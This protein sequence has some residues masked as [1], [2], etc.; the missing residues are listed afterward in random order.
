MK[1]M[2]KL[3]SILLALTLLFALAACN[4][5]GENTEG[6]EGTENNENVENNG[7]TST[8]EFSIGVIQ[9]ASH[10]ALD[11]AREG[12]VAGLD[13][14]GLSYEI[15]VLNA[16]GEQANCPT[17]ATKLVND[18]VDLILAIATPAAQAAAQATDTIPILVTA[19]TDPAYAGLVESNDAPGGNVS[20]TSDM[21]P[22]EDQIEL[23][24]TL[25][26]ET[27]TVGLLYSNSEANSTTPIAEAK[28]Y[29]AG[30][31]NSI[32]QA[33]L[34]EEILTA[35]NIAV[36]HFTAS[37]SSQVQSV[38]QSMVGKVDAVYIPTDNL[39]AD[40][41]A[42]ISMVLTPEGIPTICGEGNMVNNGCLATYGFSYE[43]LGRQTAAQA[44]SILKDGADIST[45]PIGFY[46]GELELIVNDEVAAEL[47]IEIPA[48][49]MQ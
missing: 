41:M 12:F 40:T 7:E 2:K 21:N 4:T 33:N 30:E 42:T 32:L 29:H 8:A 24:L 43:E 17:L 15:E 27:K 44:V 47:G 34:A 23:L 10:T 37:D 48:D 39:M 3:L 31:D 35:K 36:E 1:K 25:A 6:N 19:V 26:P 13:E 5:T 46:E 49:L 18:Q 45:M 11:A 20:G 14:A 22:V 9:L 28:A 16:A 38:A